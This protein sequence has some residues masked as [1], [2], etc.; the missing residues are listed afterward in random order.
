VPDF[1]LDSSPPLFLAVRHY[2]HRPTPPS[3]PNRKEQPAFTRCTFFSSFP[4]PAPSLR[5]VSSK[6][7]Q[8]TNILSSG[9][10]LAVRFFS[11]PSSLV[12]VLVHPLI[13]Q[14]PVAQLRPKGLLHFPPP[15]PNCSLTGLL[16]RPTPT[17]PFAKYG[18]RRQGRTRFV[19][20]FED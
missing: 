12:F 2:R 18:G 8:Q 5:P 19:S 20:V 16:T 1:F 17:P 9:A 10:I 4:S 13:F 6:K 15:S 14:T 11:S 7:C 3:D